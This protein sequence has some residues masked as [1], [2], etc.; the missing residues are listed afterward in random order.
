MILHPSAIISI[1]GARNAA[2]VVS[3]TFNQA[4]TAI[5]L[6]HVLAG[7]ASGSLRSRTETTTETRSAECALAV[8][9][10]TREKDAGSD[11]GIFING[12]CKDYEVCVEDNTSSLGGRCTNFHSEEGVTRPKAH[13]S[14]SSSGPCGVNSYVS[15]M[16]CTM[17]DGITPGKKCDGGNG[18]CDGIDPSQVSCGSCNNGGA[19]RGAAGPIGESSCNGFKACWGAA[20]PIGASS[21]NVDSSCYKAAGTIGGSSCNGRNTC[22]EA[23]GPIGESSCNEYLACYYLDCELKFC[24]L[25]N[26]HI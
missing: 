22:W 2:L 4:V 9:P 6:D 14:L 19:C 24:H 20:G 10:E 17:L 18:N 5:N 11:I 12:S 25:S 13:R 1:S 16:N 26:G 3:F 8:S 7:S 21:C 23:A 15:C